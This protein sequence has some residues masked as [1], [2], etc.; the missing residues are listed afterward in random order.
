[1]PKSALQDYFGDAGLD[2]SPVFTIRNG[3][4]R[5]PTW[6][7]RTPSASPNWRRRFSIALLGTGLT[8]GLR[9][10]EQEVF[11]GYALLSDRTVIAGLALGSIM[12]LG[13]Y[14]GKG[15]HLLGEVGLN[16]PF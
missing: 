5:S 6:A 9:V 1:V 16:E 7:R 15:R 14:M 8:V 11:G 2:P 4:A 3:P 12:F 13:S 10:T